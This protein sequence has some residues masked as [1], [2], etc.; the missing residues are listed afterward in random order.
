MP[1]SMVAATVAASESLGG[2]D[3][4]QI[5]AIKV[6]ILAEP[7]Q[8]MLSSLVEDATRWEVESGEIR[9]FFPTE[10]RG[11]ADLLQARERMEKLRNITS[12]VLGQ[13]LRVCVKLEAAPVLMST[14]R[15]GQNVRELRARFE[16]DPIVRA[17]LER[18]GGKISEVKPRGGE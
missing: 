12:R 2:L 17:M 14:V 3:A 18:F 1:V 10:R 11:L 9:L 13:S 4:A 15:A 5:A 7:N 16:Q 6:A 8:Q